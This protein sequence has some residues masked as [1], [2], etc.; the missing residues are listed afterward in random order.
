MRRSALLQT[1]ERATTTAT[2]NENP[3]VRAV[4]VFDAEGKVSGSVTAGLDVTAR[5]EAEDALREN[6][7]KYE[8]LAR[9]NELLY[10][11][12]QRITE[13]LQ[14]ALLSIPSEQGRLRLGHLYRSATLQAAVGGDFYDV[15]AVKSGQTAVLIGDVSG[16]GVEAARIA[17][18]V[19][20]AAHAFAHY[21]RHPRSV[22]RMTNDL[23]TEKATPGFVTLFL[24][25]LDQETGTLTYASAGHPHGLLRRAD[26]E[27]EW[28]QAGSAPLGLFPGYSWPEAGTKLLAGDTLLLY[29][30]GT[31]EARREGEFFGQ[32][33]LVE[34]LAHWSEPSPELL[35]QAILSEVLSFAGGELTDDAAILA[36]TWAAD[37]GANLLL[38]PTR[39]AKV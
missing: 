31:Y 16:H 25:I 13:T 6:E 18:L 22:L 29:T 36:L 17:T 15:F 11:E 24:G 1:A 7:A 39:P 28:L 30:D 32:E 19:K 5:Q 37:T 23:L 38:A 21:S 8:A 12:Q 9:E 20:D 33:R 35:P 3:L 14:A 4:P 26:G 34:I 2:T 10:L 27:V